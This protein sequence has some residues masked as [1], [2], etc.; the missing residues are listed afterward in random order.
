MRTLWV[1]LSAFLFLFAGAATVFGMPAEV[2]VIRHGEK[3]ADKG[4]KHLSPAG[5]KRAKSFVPFL[6]ENSIL[7]QHGAPVALFATKK[8]KN[9]RGQRPGETLQPLSKSLKLPIQKPFESEDAGSLAKLILSNPSYNGKTVL[10]CWTHEF[11]P[12]LVEALGVHPAPPK[13]HDYVYDR[14]YMITY[15]NGK[16]E[17]K[18]LSQ[19]LSSDPATSK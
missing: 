8:T 13:L 9:G 15:E 11:I 2:I 1:L 17:L 14:V 10:V 19:S 3:P 12:P 18:Q 7:M 5:E 16:A 6:K 4:S